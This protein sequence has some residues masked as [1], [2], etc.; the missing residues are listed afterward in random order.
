MAYE[1]M[2]DIITTYNGD[3]D[4]VFCENDA[5]AMGAIT[6][7]EEANLNPA[8]YIV[9]GIDGIRQGYENI[10]DGKQF[11]T[12]VNSPI[13]VADLTVDGVDRYL[14]G[15]VTVSGTTYTQWAIVTADNVSDY[16]DVN[17]LY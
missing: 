11:A 13:D 16:Y 9:L 8:D 10:M 4:V 14:N 2:V 6:A 3:F 17:S 12:G 1:K 15:D 5:M 7:I